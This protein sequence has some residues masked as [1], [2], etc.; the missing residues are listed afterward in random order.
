[1]GKGEITSN[2]SFFSTVFLTDL[3][4]IHKKIR[5]CLERVKKENE[6]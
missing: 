1:M 3:Y 5:A 2:F 6:Y 4:C